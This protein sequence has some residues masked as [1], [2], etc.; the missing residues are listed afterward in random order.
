[1]SAQYLCLQ[2]STSALVEVLQAFMQQGFERGKSVFTT[3]LQLIK[4]QSINEAKEI[5]HS[6][7]I[8]SIVSTNFKAP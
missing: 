3:T 2:T 5:H 7:K 4:R 6:E 8:L 1:M